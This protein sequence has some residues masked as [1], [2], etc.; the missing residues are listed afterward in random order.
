MITAALTA[1]ISLPSIAAANDDAAKFYKGKQVTIITG[2]SPGGGYDTYARLLARHMTKHMAGNP[3]FLVKNMPGA[4][5]ERAAAYVANVAPKDGTV[6]AGV[7][8]TQPLARIFI[9][10]SKLTYDP[11]KQRYLGSAS[12]DTFVCMIRKDAPVKTVGDLFQ[13]QLILGSGARLSGTLSFMPNMEQSLLGTKIRIVLGYKG[14][15][16]I[17]AAMEKGEVHGLCGIN[18]SSINSRYS[19]FLKNGLARIL[20][21]ETVE[22]DPQLN[23]AN[24]PRT[25][26]LAKSEKHKKIMRT[27]YAQGD[28]ARPF[29]VAG[30]TPE[31]RIVALQKAFLSAL[32]DKTLLA[33]AEKQRLGITAIPGSAIQAIV[34]D[35]A[36]QPDDFIGEVRKSIKLN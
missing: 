17:V 18:L 29:F 5:G 25:Y 26:D 6:I 20:L 8:A 2:F 21:Q 34:A 3:S 9:P 33:E 4:G 19:H 7:S 32:A 28:F 23:A 24:I 31:N 22:G 36:K 15:A 13:K 1:A 35:I 27:V 30:S 11:S 16:D 10:K 14:S 12:K